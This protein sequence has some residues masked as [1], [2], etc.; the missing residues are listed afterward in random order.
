M[1]LPFSSTGLNHCRFWRHILLLA[2]KFY[3]WTKLWFLVG[4]KTWH[5]DFFYLPCFPHDKEFIQLFQI[6]KYYW[7]LLSLRC[8]KFFCNMCVSHFFVV[9]FL[10]LKLNTFWFYPFST[11]F[12]ILAH[13]LWAFYLFLN[14][15]LGK[16]LLSRYCF[17]EYKST[18]QDSISK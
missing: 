16:Y 5:S 14:V 8:N 13:F 2:I 7:V 4:N 1:D 15:V 6:G 18:G 10:R 3:C 17:S 9:K 11:N 12:Q